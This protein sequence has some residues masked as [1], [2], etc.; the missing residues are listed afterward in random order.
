MAKIYY[1]RDVKKEYLEGKTVAVIGYGS[2][3]RGQALNLHDSGIKVVVGLR[4]G[5]K[6]L[7]LVEKD[8]LKAMSISEATKI[9]DIVQILI[10]DEVQAKVYYQEGIEENLREGNVLMFS[11]GFNIHFSQIIPPQNVDVIMVAPKSPGRLVREMYLQGKGVPNLIAV[12]QDYSGKAKEI[13]L[14][15]SWAIGGTRAGTIETT[16]KEETE[17]DLFG[18]QTVLCGGVTALIQAGF[19]VLVEAG[20]QPEIAYFECLNELKLIVDLI[21][22]GGITYM[23]DNVSNTAE[24]GDLKVGKRI[25]NEKTRQEMKKVLAEIQSG[26]FAKDWILENQAGKPYYRAMRNKEANYLIEKVG[27]ELRKMM[28]WIKK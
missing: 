4:E 22:Q 17:T 27:E 28:P 16:F 15:Y 11:H 7:D 25:V 13:G 5:S 8:G 20:Y 1:D 12:Y 24:Y 2:Q 19:D 6:S 23:R 21:Y 26:E 10:P 14:A 18:E 3:G 9:G